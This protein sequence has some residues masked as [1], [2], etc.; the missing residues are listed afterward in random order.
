MN[1][2]MTENHKL[3]YSST[4]RRTIK[5]NPGQMRLQHCEVIY[6]GH[7]HVAKGL[8]ADLSK[9][10]A[11]R[12]MLAPVHVKGALHSNDTFSVQVLPNLAAVSGT[13]YM[14]S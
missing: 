12:D 3:F 6:V 14:S 8:K 1:E 11:I 9:I 13:L 7:L 2:T 5:L 4:G 10:K